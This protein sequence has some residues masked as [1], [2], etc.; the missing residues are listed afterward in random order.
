MSWCGIG[1]ALV[2]HASQRY[3]SPVLWNERAIA[4]IKGHSGLFPCWAILPPQTGEQLPTAEFLESARSL[5][6]KA[7]WAFPQE[8][9]YCLDSLT[10]GDLLEEL[11]ARRIPLF[12]KDNA[13][14]IYNVMRE[15]PN[16]TAIAVN[17]GPHSLERYLRPMLDRYPNL[18]LDTAYYIVDGLIEEFCDR[19]GPERLL[20]G[21]GFP[22]NCSGGALLR[23]LHAD[24]TDDARAA[25]AG[26]NLQRLLDEADL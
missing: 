26:G 5:G 2:R 6:V 16:L 7:L 20:F 18:H 10:L 4:D 1:R 17:Q 9:R 13:I 12:V 3:E 25:V 24:I 8:H 11:S 15:F 21:S 22:D 14:N 19:Y 23:L